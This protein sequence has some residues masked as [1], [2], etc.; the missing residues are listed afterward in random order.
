MQAISPAECK[1]A[2]DAQVWRGT[3]LQN[4]SK[5]IVG[6]QRE[7]VAQYSWCCHS[8]CTEVENV[9][10]QLGSVGT[11]D[12]IT[13]TSDLADLSGCNPK[14]LSCSKDDGVV[15]WDRVLTAPCSYSYTG[16]FSAKFSSGF[17]LTDQLQGAFSVGRKPSATPEAFSCIPSNA[18]FTE[19]GVVLQITHHNRSDN[20][21]ALITPTGKFEL[22]HLTPHE[23]F[24]AP[25]ATQNQGS[26]HPPAS[27]PID[28]KL[29]WLAIRL[30][31]QV[32]NNFVTQWRSLCE[33]A[34]QELV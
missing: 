21:G 30:E 19:Q 29:T 9:L 3:P 28:A 25:N 5:G 14:G 18:L 15:V 34:R 1:A 24:L 12:G 7:I 23:Q 16:S 8:V 10:V 13:L 20:L 27:D 4:I 33:L 31:H 17:I 2:I 32:M 6:T 11:Y 26:H 22:Y